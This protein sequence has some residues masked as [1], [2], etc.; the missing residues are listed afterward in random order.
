[1]LCFCGS[2][3]FG[4]Y[5]FPTKKASFVFYFEKP[6]LETSL[7]LSLIFYFFKWENKIRKKTLDVTYDK[8]MQ[9]WENRV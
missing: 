2:R 3:I 9:V 7:E 4:Y 1:M 6:F 8:K 5:T